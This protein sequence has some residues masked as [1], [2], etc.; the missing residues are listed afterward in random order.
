MARADK[1]LRPIRE[2][3]PLAEPGADLGMA[4]RQLMQTFRQSMD[5]ALDELKSE[6][7]FKG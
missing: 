6:G 1:S 5:A 4:L 3:V 2:P 7:H